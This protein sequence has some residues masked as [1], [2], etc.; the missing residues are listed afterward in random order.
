MVDAW[1]GSWARARGVSEGTGRFEKAAGLARTKQP[2]LGA[3]TA[4]VLVPLEA[5]REAGW[6]VHPNPAFSQLFCQSKV[7]QNE[8][9]DRC[10]S[11]QLRVSL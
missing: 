3:V 8:E 2:P 11:G 10:P 6:R 9:L 7:I 1:V 4:V 5:A